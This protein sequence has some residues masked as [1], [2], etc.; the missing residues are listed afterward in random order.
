[1]NPPKT[2]YS[3]T[4]VAIKPSHLIISWIL[5]ALSPIIQ[6]SRYSTHGL[7]ESVYISW[8]TVLEGLIKHTC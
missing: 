7:I 4:S 5:Q 6:L 1:M 8:M 3:T 2:Y